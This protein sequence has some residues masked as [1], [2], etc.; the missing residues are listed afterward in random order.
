MRHHGATRQCRC[1][2]KPLRNS[3]RRG[4]AVALAKGVSIQ[5]RRQGTFDALLSNLQCQRQLRQVINTVPQ[6]PGAARDDEVCRLEAMALSLRDQQRTQER[7]AAA[8]A[9]NTN[10]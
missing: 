2:P 1:A 7:A 4:R 8:G 6:S 5:H 10:K 9:K 3:F